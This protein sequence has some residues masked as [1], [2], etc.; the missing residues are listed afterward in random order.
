MDKVVRSVRWDTKTL[1][2]QVVPT[3]KG[4]TKAH[5]YLILGVTQCDTYFPC[6]YQSFKIG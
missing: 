4:K 1:A 3:T 2:Q 5:L 6:L